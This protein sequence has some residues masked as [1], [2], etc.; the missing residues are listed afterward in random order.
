M[1]KKLYEESNIQ[2]IAN[3]IREK[4]GT[5]STYKTSEMGNAIRSIQSGGNGLNLI[6]YVQTWNQLFQSV[7]FKE[8]TEININSKVSIQNNI[9]N[10]FV[11]TRN[12]EKVKL[13]AS[14]ISQPITLNY[15]FNNTDIEELDISG[16]DMKVLNA[17]T[18]FSASNK[19]KKIIGVFDFSNALNVSNMFSGTPSLE[20]VRFV[21]ETLKLSTSF[22]DSSLLS[23]DSIQSIIDGLATVENSQTLTLHADV[24]AKLTEEQL[25]TITSKNWT[26]A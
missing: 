14:F 12:V 15:A 17:Y 24:K 26:L 20:E 7:I 13:S 2:D 25:T 10:M 19:L 16:L 11:S 8:N 6:E 23:A 22:K 18:A 3:A 5:E 1:A 21:Q 4:N 9:S